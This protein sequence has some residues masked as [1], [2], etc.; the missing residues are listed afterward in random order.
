MTPGVTGE[1]SLTGLP[2]ILRGMPRIKTLAGQL[3]MRMTLKPG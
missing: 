2:Q 1:M 3:G